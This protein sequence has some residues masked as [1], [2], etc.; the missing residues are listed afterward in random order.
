MKIKEISIKRYRSILNLTLEIDDIDK[1]STI[2]GANNVGKTNVLR[3][4]DTFFNPLNY[5]ADKDSPHHKFYGTRGAK[6]YPEIELKFIDQ[7]HQ[8]EIKRIFDIEGLNE[9]KGEKTEIST[10]TKTTLSDQ[11]IES[12]LIKT[13][14]FFIPSINISTPELINNLIDDLYDI[15][16]ENRDLED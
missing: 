12:L 1:I 15:E 13:P 10:G 14:F 2:C 7:N 8:F 16:Y 11:E 3:A 9:T 5:I 6:V 4:I